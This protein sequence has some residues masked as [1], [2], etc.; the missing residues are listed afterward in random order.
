MSEEM[1]NSPKALL[2]LPLTSRLVFAAPRLME[3]MS[4]DSLNVS[5]LEPIIDNVGIDVSRVA[6]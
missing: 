4:C 2:N 3:T 1:V 5:K 6:Q